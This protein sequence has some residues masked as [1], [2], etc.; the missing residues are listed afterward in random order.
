MSYMQHMFTYVFD[1]SVTLASNCNGTFRR[2]SRRGGTRTQWPGKME[3]WVAQWANAHE[4]CVPEDGPYD[5]SAYDEYLRWYAP[6]T[7]TRLVHVVD[8]PPARVPALTD[9][10]P[11][12]LARN[13][14]LVVRKI[15]FENV[16][17]L[18]PEL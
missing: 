13:V 15:V 1:I 17:V 7:R 10:Y 2:H 3:P 8:P 5:P 6:Q 16:F 12:H 14:H 11:L 4:D 9:A 18:L